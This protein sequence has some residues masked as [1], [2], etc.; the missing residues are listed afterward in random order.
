[1]NC[2][3]AI[4]PDITPLNKCFASK[5]RLPHPTEKNKQRPHTTSAGDDFKFDYMS[6]IKLIKR[7]FIHSTPS[8][9]NGHTLEVFPAGKIK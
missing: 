1:M 8:N 2:C 9:N 7:I 5:N 6:N 4:Q 3:R